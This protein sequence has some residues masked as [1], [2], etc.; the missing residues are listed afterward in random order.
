MNLNVL[1]NDLPFENDDDVIGKWQ[2][3]DVVQLEEE[4]DLN[5]VKT[6]ISNRGFKEIYFLP[7]GQ[8][9]W[10]F[11]GWTKGFL[12][13]HYGGNE[14]INCNKYTI[15][16]I[17]NEMYM[18]LQVND[19]ILNDYQT[20]INVLKKVSNKKYKL[21]E[22]GIHDNID[23]PFIIDENILGLWKCVDFIENINEFTINKQKS[24]TLWLKSVCFNNDGTVVRVYDN[25]QWNDF[26]TEG[27]LIDKIK[28]TTSAYEIKLVDNKE[29]LFLEWKMGNYIYGGA[30]PIYYVFERCIG[31]Y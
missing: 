26:W 24:T 19:N 27:V 29:Y 18:F 16:K 25:E 17:N 2:Y 15:K 7:N 11:E 4:F 8:K 12:F 14:P 13:T 31:C 20:Y 30:K 6:K 21:S 5:N 28:V 23:L 1:V 3:Y 22:I 10:V 9:Y